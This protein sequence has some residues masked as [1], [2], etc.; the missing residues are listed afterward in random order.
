MFVKMKQIQFG[1]KVN[2]GGFRVL[3]KI[4]IVSLYKEIFVNLN[5]EGKN[6][7]FQIWDADRAR[8]DDLLA[9][10]EVPLNS[11]A[12]IKPTC[13]EQISETT[14][15]L[16]NENGEP[17]GTLSYSMKLAYFRLFKNIISDIF[18]KKGCVSLVANLHNSRTMEPNVHYKL[19]LIMLIKR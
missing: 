2:K 6:I 7:I 9:T 8:T 19:E 4:L 10:L 12:S 13:E 14:A 3:E 11:I 5:G 15:E 17:T 16:Q 18:L 1:I